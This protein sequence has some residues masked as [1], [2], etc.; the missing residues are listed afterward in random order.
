MGVG[1]VPPRPLRALNGA[2]NV[3]MIS[4]LLGWGSTQD[5]GTLWEYQ[6]STSIPKTA[7]PWRVQPVRDF[8]KWPS[9]D[10][11]KLLATSP[12]RRNGM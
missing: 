8:L 4:L 5:I 11:C 12:G 1:R 10:G 9:R 7:F 6:E 2:N 3:K